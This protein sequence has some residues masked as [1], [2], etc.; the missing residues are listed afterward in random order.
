YLNNALAQAAAKADVAYVDISQ[1]LAGHRLCE[2]PSYDIAINGLTAGTDGGPLGLK[3][4]GKE[5]YHPNALGQGLIEQAI[6]KQT[7]NLAAGA[8]SGSTSNT[9]SGQKLLNAPKTGRTINHRLAGKNLASRVTKRGSS[10][11]I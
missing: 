6:L 4:F 11:G 2:A 9:D 7:H 5:S 10:T 8:A 1:A 3:V